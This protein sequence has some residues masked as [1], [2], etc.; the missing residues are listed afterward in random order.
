MEPQLLDRQ[1]DDE[2]RRAMEVISWLGQ[3][4]HLAA[5]AM[6]NAA[7]RTA[8]GNADAHTDDHVDTSVEVS[9]E[10]GMKVPTNGP[11]QSDTPV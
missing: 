4:G 6:D 11:L 10:G 7:S 1:K 2:D 5:P 8:D 9:V 3:N